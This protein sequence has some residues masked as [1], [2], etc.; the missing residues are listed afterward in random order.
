MLVYKNCRKSFNPTP[1]LDV[2]S[3]WARSLARIKVSAFGAGDRGFKSH[4]ARS[5]TRVARGYL[6]FDILIICCQLDEQCHLDKKLFHPYRLWKSV[7]YTQKAAFRNR[8]NHEIT[9]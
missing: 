2:L 7:V 5:L 8:H 1:L 4:R 3:M 6:I 9:I